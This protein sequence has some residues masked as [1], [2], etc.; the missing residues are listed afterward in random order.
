M[1]KLVIKGIYILIGDK[2]IQNEGSMSSFPYIVNE[3]YFKYI[4]ISIIFH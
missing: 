2:L 3:I 4:Y 1:N